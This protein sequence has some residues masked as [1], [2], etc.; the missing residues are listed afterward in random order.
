MANEKPTKYCLLNVMLLNGTRVSGKFHIEARTTST[1][2]PSDAIREARDGFLLLTESGT[3]DSG[4]LRESR[5]LMIPVRA[6]A[7][8]ELP[9]TRWTT[10]SMS[11]LVTAAAAS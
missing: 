3:E 2:R 5:T 11:P 10:P 8:V 4:Q 6:I 1:I 9:S 7:F